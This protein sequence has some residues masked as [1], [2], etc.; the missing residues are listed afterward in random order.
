MALLGQCPRSEFVK[1]LQRRLRAPGRGSFIG[2]NRE[3]GCQER[4]SQSSYCCSGV[5]TRGLVAEDH[6][7]GRIKALRSDRAIQES[8]AAS[9]SRG[10]ISVFPPSLSR[11]W[12]QLERKLLP[13]LGGPVIV[14][15]MDVAVSV[16]VS[17]LGVFISSSFPCSLTD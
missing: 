4:A 16:F 7:S 6:S 1:L 8:R 9:W 12:E 5:G 10:E 14:S 13:Q 3:P 2:G 11:R 17:S 15:V